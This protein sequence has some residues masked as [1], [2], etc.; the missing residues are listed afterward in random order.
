MPLKMKTKMSPKR[1][2]NSPTP[3]GDIQM[4]KSGWT[5]FKVGLRLKI[6]K[7]YPLRGKGYFM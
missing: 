5:L 1:R 2:D 6:N 7:L 4:K 3:G